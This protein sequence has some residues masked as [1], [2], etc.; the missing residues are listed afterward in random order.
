MVSKKERIEGLEALAVLV[1]G[2]P[3]VEEAAKRG[4]VE[5][6]LEGLGLGGFKVHK[7]L[8]VIP[9]VCRVLIIC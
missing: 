9:R 7:E 3:K 1:E 2:L 8:E 5:D 6:C 4:N